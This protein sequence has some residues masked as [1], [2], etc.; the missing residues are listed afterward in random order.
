MHDEASLH[1]IGAFV[2]AP[3]WISDFRNVG[4]DAGLRQCRGLLVPPHVISSLWIRQITSLTRACTAHRI[5]EAEN[6]DCIPVG[7]ITHVDKHF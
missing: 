1:C 2:F 6:Y 4:W 3:G 5:F 7:N